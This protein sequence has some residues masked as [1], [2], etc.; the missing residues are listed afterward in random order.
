MKN[1]TKRVAVSVVALVAV[2]LVAFAV[3][4]QTDSGAAAPEPKGLLAKVAAN[5]GVSVDDLVAAFTA[6]RLEMIDEA[7]AAGE[8]TAEQAQVMKER[9]EARQALR[10]VLAEA[11]ED[12][13]ITRDQLAL[14]RGQPDRRPW[15][16]RDRRMDRDCR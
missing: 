4:A 3:F 15:R 8:I 14:L 7:V 6:A 2:A 16:M 1:Q 11:I 12:G 9:I 5:L 13:K 10:V